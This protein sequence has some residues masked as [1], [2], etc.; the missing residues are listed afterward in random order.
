MVQRYASDLAVHMGGVTMRRRTQVIGSLVL[1]ILFCVAIPGCLSTTVVHNMTQA[2]AFVGLSIRDAEKKAGDAGIQV[3]VTSSESSDTMPVD[4]VLRQD[5]E[6]QTMVKKGSIVTVVTSSGQVSLV[7]QN[8]VG[9][10]FEAAQT[11]ITKN[12][13]VL[14]DLI[15]KTDPSTVGT[16]LAQNPPANSDIT[17]GATVTLTISKGTM[18]AMPDL[19]GASLADARKQLSVLGLTVSRVI[20]AAH[21]TQPAQLVLKQEP[22]AGDSIATGGWIELTVSKT[23]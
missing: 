9:G 20:V 3:Q 23:P 13:L 2:P 4:F 1:A 15:E 14:G 22:A 8:F 7:L 10:T 19:I 17:R 16:V 6:P 12:Q 5:P 11:F 18:A 21:T